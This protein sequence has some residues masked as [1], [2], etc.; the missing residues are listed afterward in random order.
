MQYK[1]ENRINILGLKPN[2]LVI[3]NNNLKKKKF[4]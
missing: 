4:G 2:E 1:Y 3:Y